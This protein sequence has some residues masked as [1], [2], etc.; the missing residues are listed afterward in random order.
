MISE[1]R[2]TKDA[3]ARLEA[4]AAEFPDGTKSKEMAVAL[5]DAIVAIHVRLEGLEREIGPG[6]S[7]I[8]PTD[9][10]PNRVR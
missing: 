9:G 7:M 4:L 5:K 3:I 2:M 6:E 10:G 1:R 8:D